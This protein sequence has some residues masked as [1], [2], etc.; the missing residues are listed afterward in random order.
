MFNHQKRVGA[1]AETALV[2]GATLQGVCPEA[3]VAE[4]GDLWVL[5][6]PHISF[7]NIRGLER[8]Q[9]QAIR[10]ELHNRAMIETL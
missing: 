8:P 10:G 3:L 1:P 9:E 2:G 7:V 5:Q 6:P 4:P